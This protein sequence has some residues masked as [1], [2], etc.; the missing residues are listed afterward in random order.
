M[1]GIP[2]WAIGAVVILTGVAVMQSLLYIVRRRLGIP[3]PPRG[4][5][6]GRGMIG[7]SLPDESRDSGEHA[8]ALD[9]LQRR[10]GELEERLDFAERM[11]AQQREAGQLAPPKA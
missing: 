7:L 4:G 10:V 5:R 9:D 11:L 2:S 3:E 1:L 8:A 6:R